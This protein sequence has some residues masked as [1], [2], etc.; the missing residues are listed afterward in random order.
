MKWAL[1]LSMICPL[2]AADIKV[3]APPNATVVGPYS[4]GLQTADFL[5]VSGQGA[6]NAEGK[7]AENAEQQ[8][9]DCLQNIQAIVEAAGLTMDHI[10]YTQVYVKDT[11][12]YEA[13]D[14]AWRKVFAR[15]SPARSLLG[16]HRMP[17]ETP[18][19]I[20]AVAVTNPATKKLVQVNGW[21]ADAPAPAAVIAGDRV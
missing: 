2:L 13:V 3:I 10:V 18:V 16:V 20:S 14:R 1:A 6:R 11:A 9:L 7:F 8:V 19:E 5:Y 12:A 4:P 15:N 17:T 21:P